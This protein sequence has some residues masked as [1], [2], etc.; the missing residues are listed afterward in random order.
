MPVVKHEPPVVLA[1]VVGAVRER[2]LLQAAVA[3][4]G[5]ARPAGRRRDGPAAADRRHRRAG[6]RSP[7][8]ASRQ[9]LG[10]ARARRRPSGR[11]HH[12]APT[13][14]AASSHGRGRAD[15]GPRRQGL[16]HPCRARRRPARPGHRRGGARRSRWPRPSQQE[17]VGKPLGL[18]VRPQRQPHP[19]RARD[20]TSP[21]SR[22]PRTGSP[23]RRAWPPRTR[24]CGCSRPA[25]TCSCP[26]TPTAAR[27][28]SRS[29]C[30][31]RP[32]WPS[33]PSTSPTSTR[34]RAAWQP[35]TRMVWVETPSNPWLR[36]VDI[37]AVSALAHERGAHRRRRQHLR[38]PRAAAAARARRRR[39]RALDHQVPRRP[40]RR[41][42]R[43]RRHRRRRAGRAH[44]LP[45]ERGRRGA[46]AR[47]T[48]TSC[49][50]APARCSCAWRATARSRPAVAELPGRPPGRRRGPATP[51]CRRTPATTS[52]RARCRRFG[53]MVSFRLA[54]G[55]AAALEVCRRTELFTLAESLGAVESL[56]E[57]PGR[58]THASV[59]GTA[60]EVP[61]RPRPPVGRHRGR[62]RPL[63][64]LR[65]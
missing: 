17:A 20:A 11:R 30:T 61:G 23:S 7:S 22:A 64:D 26:T 54:G 36:I 58:M 49:T 41:R 15:G 37:E 40:Q 43:L 55:E 32:A 34:S 6:R 56:I 1:E 42:R 52:P 12:A 45:A 29:R 48:A 62:R 9:R 5:R 65:A 57:H 2:E 24:C 38:H 8:R 63:A 33:T 31:R 14:S 53:G 59:A 10:R 25:T 27:S 3:D 39:R 4:A 50:A 18:R 46:R 19:H 44:R 16:R 28:A 21:R 47:S 60:N 51:G 35:A 13:C